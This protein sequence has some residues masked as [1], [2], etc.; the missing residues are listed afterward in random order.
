[1]NKF[2]NDNKYDIILPMDKFKK[3]LIF[4]QKSEQ[5]IYDIFS[6]DPRI[7]VKTERNQWKHTGNIFVEYEC[8][9][10]PSG[11]KVSEAKTWI[12]C[13]YYNGLIEHSIIF[14]LHWLKHILRE[15][16]VKGVAKKINGGDDNLSKGLLIPIKEIVK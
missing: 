7:E 10:K 4:G 11:I 5:Y 16:Y 2:N 15:L 14:N 1:M 13:F 8:R 9:G 3:D 12:I 6:N